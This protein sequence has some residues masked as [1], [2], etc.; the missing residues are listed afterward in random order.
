MSE[1][2]FNT[3]IVHKHDIEENWNKAVNFIPKQGELIVYDIDANHEYSRV[4]IGDGEKTVINLP[5]IDK[6]V[7]DA[8]DNLITP[9]DIDN[10]CGQTIA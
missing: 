1:Q 8:M 7:I 5:F 9:K 10:I 4:K 6:P 2:I 3:R